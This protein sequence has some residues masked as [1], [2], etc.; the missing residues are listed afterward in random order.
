MTFFFKQFTLFFTRYKIFKLFFRIKKNVQ[1][2]L[3]L[4]RVL[5]IKKKGLA[6]NLKEFFVILLKRYNANFVKQI[7]YFY[8]KKG[9]KKNIKICVSFLKIVVEYLYL[10]TYF[11][12]LQKQCIA[13]KRHF[14]FNLKIILIKKN[15]YLTSGTLKFFPSN[16]LRFFS[17]C[18]FPQ[19]LFIYKSVL[20]LNST[21]FNKNFNNSYKNLFFIL[22]K[23]KI[24]KHF[25]SRPVTWLLSYSELQIFFFFEYFI[26]KIL[27][28]TLIVSKYLILFLKKSLEKSFLLTLAKKKSRSSVFCFKYFKT[29]LCFVKKKKKV[30]LFEKC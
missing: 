24:S 22:D 30:I 25:Y 27:K 5:R 2:F 14:N 26:S 21:P 4:S 20:A 8:T 7:I 16:I 28:Y 19:N 3:K 11:K 12:K 17:I 23:F 29:L 18:Y 15:F 9:L 1:P 13:I 6:K 10:F